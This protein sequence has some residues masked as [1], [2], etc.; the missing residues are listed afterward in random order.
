MALSPDVTHLINI[1][2]QRLAFNIPEYTATRL[3][4]K[5]TRHISNVSQCVQSHVDTEEHSMHDV[6]CMQ[7]RKYLK[8]L[9][10]Y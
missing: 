3:R 9:C 10:K 7:C 6:Y 4:E 5:A 2:L 1:P 8:H